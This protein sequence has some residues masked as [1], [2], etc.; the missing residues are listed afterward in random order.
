MY[1][2]IGLPNDKIEIQNNF[3]IINGKKCKTTFIKKTQSEQFDVNEFEEEL[4]NG[5]RH[6]IYT[7]I[8]PF[9]DNK[10]EVTKIK[11]PKNCYYLMG[12]NRD[13]AMDSRYI[14]VINEDEIKGKIVF[15]YWG[16]TK[17]RININFRDK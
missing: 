10:N 8:N 3:L 12:D 7:F 11:I 6:K 17:D 1:R 5:H 14:G 13:N 4:P 9:N 2:I 15:G 16:N